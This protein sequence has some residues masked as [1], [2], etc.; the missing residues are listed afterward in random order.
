MAEGVRLIPGI[1]WYEGPP[2]MSVTVRLPRQSFL[3]GILA[4]VSD[5]Q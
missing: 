4:L 5:S 3:V 1:A 2:W